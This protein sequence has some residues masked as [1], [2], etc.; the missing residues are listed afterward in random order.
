M[1]ATIFV[2]LLAALIGAATNARSVQPAVPGWTALPLQAGEYRRYERTNRQ[3]FTS[4]LVADEQ[5][6]R[7]QPKEFSRELSTAL[8]KVPGST[9]NIAP[10]NICGEPGEYTIGTGL[11]RTV[12]RHNLEVYAFRKNGTFYVLEDIFD[13]PAPSPAAHEL[14]AALCP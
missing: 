13:S 8:A 11:A 7:C 2:P 10:S 3:G 5:I 6:C 14:L 4:V 1:A 12:G 9:V